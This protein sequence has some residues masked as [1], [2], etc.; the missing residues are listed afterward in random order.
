MQ[1]GADVV[2]NGMKFFKKFRRGLPY[3]PAVPLLDIY[4]KEVEIKISKRYMLSHVHCSMIHNSQ[5][6]ETT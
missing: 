5:D 6:V 1:N 4:L 3:N 2:Q